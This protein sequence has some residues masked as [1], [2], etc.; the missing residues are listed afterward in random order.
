MNDNAECSD[1]RNRDQESKWQRHSI[2]DVE[3]IDHVHPAH[4][5]VGIG[6]P[7]DIDHAENQIQAERQKRQY[8]AEQDAV[9]DRLDEIRI[10]SLQPHI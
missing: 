3:K 6:D 2:F 4:D 10:H 8:A 1:A 5:D 9:D 7:H